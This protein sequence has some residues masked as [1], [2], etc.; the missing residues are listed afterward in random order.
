[1]VQFMLVTT[2]TCKVNSYFVSCIFS[3][4][5]HSVCEQSIGVRFVCVCVCVL[6]VMNIDGCPDC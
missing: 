4:V 1:M 6:A 3:V 2:S 5:Q